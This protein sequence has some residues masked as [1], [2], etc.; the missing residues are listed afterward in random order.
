MADIRTCKECGR[1]YD[2]STSRTI[3]TSGTYCSEGCERKGLAAAKSSSS[4]GPVGATTPIDS[5]S[6]WRALRLIGIAFVALVT[7][8]V[9]L[10]Y[11]FPKFLKEKN[12]KFLYAYIIAWAVLIG[13]TVV[14]FSFF[15][16]EA[17]ARIKTKIV[18]TSCET[19]EEFITILK[20]VSSKVASKASWTALGGEEFTIYSQQALGAVK[21]KEGEDGLFKD[22][23]YF[24]RLPESVNVYIWFKTKDQTAA[25]VYKKKKGIKEKPNPT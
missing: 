20:K 4:R 17:V 7:V 21:E 6:L 13:G 22:A 8:I 18:S 23:V 11:K 10:C 15:S 2:S 25:Y 5:D 1:R 19:Q 3:K 12:K 14:Y 9:V 24:V 16:P